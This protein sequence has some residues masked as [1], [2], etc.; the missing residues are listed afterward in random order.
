[1]KKC[2]P[3]GTRREEVLE[4]DESFFLVR[5]LKQ[6]RRILIL[7]QAYRVWLVADGGRLAHFW[8]LSTH[9]LGPQKQGNSQLK[10]K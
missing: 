1:M 6:A 4:I 3:G 9:L 7:G 2:R 8:W 10:Q 5:G